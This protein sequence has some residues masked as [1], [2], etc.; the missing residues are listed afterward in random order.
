[1]TALTWVDYAQTFGLSSLTA[2]NVTIYP[3]SHQLFIGERSVPCALT[4][5]YFLELLLSNV[6]KTVS[7]ERLIRSSN[8]RLSSCELN[9]LRVQM[10]YLKRL[11]RIHG[12]QLEIRTV[13]QLGY[14]VRPINSNAPINPTPAHISRARSTSYADCT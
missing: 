10:C 12:A 8:V 4:L 13:R 7:R 5:F 6:C 9:R 11:L 14:Q 1:M 2:G 3:E